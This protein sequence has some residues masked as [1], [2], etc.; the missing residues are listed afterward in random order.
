MK[1]R[2]ALSVFIF[3][4]LGFVHFASPA[5]HDGIPSVQD[6]IAQVK[7]RLI[8]ETPQQE[9]R[10]IGPIQ[11]WKMLTEQEKEI[12][13][14]NHIRFSVSVP[15]KVM[16]FTDPSLDPEPFWLN[17]RG[18][19]RTEAQIIV[20]DDEYIGWEKTFPQGSIGLGINSF[21]EEGEQYFVA[22]TPLVKTDP[23][24]VI[25]D[26]YPNDCRIARLKEGTPPY[27]DD[28]DP[29]SSFPKE[30]EEAIL[31][32]V[33]EDWV[34]TAAIL[35]QFL[36]TK[37]PSSDQADQI[38]LTWSEDPRATQTIQWRTGPAVNKGVVAYQK[39]SGE[40]PSFPQNAQTVAA[41]STILETIDIINDPRCYRHTAVLQNLEAGTTYLYAVG[42]GLSDHWSE[43]A[44][45]KT[46]TKQAASFSFVYM[47]DAQNGL[48]RWGALLQ[49]AHRAHTDAA[50]YLFAGDLVGRGNDRDDWDDFFHNA[51][52][53]LDRK[54]IVPALGNHDCR[55]GHPSLY[56]TYFTLPINGPAM[57]ESERVYSFEYGNAL[58][59]ILDS[60]LPPE[61]QTPWLEQQLSHTEA[62]WKF[63]A[64]H[65][66]VYSSDPD[67]DNA[68]I[69]DAWTPIFDKY[70]VD[71][72]LQGH[73]H[74]YLRTHPMKS[75]QPV[76]NL[77][78]GTIYVV[79]VSGTKM[80]EQAE[81]DYTAVGFVDT[82]VY[83]LLNIHVSD[84][85][86]HYQTYD[87]NGKKHDDLII[88]K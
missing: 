30:W 25:R 88:H 19:E 31:I 54:P 43:T 59:L 55:G 41:N 68:E 39:K 34:K 26:L 14:T 2:I 8:Q 60:N 71:M 6:I 12:L 64:F 15:V 75:N 73:D 17:E 3:I 27:I 85:H 82:S 69:R 38:V 78:D 22:L 61:E 18:F 74:A 45:F 33:S 67:R 66:P 52:G 79:S 16:V 32:Q 5:S 48:D 63:V 65:H 72:V 84:N 49:N 46:A 76:D 13:T 23:P 44:E 4:I 56:F 36:F 87:I 70:H 24:P 58:I 10:N 42:D 1:R 21:T 83:Q 86:L 11:I 47:G 40:D 50:F 57:I 80:Y 29:I 28:D 35:S 37:Y 53:V 77:A 7:M 81:R 62:V 51:R 20:D 9:L